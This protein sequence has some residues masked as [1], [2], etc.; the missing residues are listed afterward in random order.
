MHVVRLIRETDFNGAGSPTA[1]EAD[2]YT[3]RPPSSAK[4]ENV[5][6][7]VGAADTHTKLFVFSLQNRRFTNER[8]M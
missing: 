7:R 2:R 3:A 4:V 8:D 6:L 5:I 1:L